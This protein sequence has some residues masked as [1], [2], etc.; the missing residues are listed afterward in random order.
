M[1]GQ[2]REGFQDFLD[3]FFFKWFNVHF[4]AGMVHDLV[5]GW[6]FDGRLVSI[7]FLRL[8]RYLSRFPHSTGV[9]LLQ[10]SNTN[11]LSMSYCVEES[12]RAPQ[13]SA[14]DD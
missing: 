14:D 5:N 10:P 11:N 13:G 6:W 1:Q 12:G 7:K 8:E 2:V 4:I 9:A 3:Y